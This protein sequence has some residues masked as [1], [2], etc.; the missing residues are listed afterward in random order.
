MY[1][2]VLVAI[3]DSDTSR[4]ALDEAAH[5]ARSHQ[6]RL[7][8]V[9]V[10]DE[11]LMGMKNRTFSTTLNLEQAIQAIIEAG[12]SLLASAARQAGDV[13]VDTQLLEARGERISDVLLRKAGEMHA[14]LVVLGR[15]GKRGIS[16]LLLGS[17]A[18]QVARNA[19]M[20][21]LLVRPQA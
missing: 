5:I 18:E 2:H 21:V 15:H 13:P 10:A 19:D 6:A 17:V 11:S 7:T 12:E 9:H 14:D 4:S 1:K 8:I 20:S 3:D 16:R